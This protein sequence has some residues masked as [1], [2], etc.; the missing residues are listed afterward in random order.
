MGRQPRQLLPGR[1]DEQQAPSAIPFDEETFTR[2]PASSSAAP[3]GRN[4]PSE[5]AKATLPNYTIE[6]PDVLLIDA[7]KVVLK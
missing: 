1:V 5:K 2:V 6:P 4:V 7:I 3:L